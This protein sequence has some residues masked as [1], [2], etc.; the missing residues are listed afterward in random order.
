[1]EVRVAHHGPLRLADDDRAEGPRQPIGLIGDLVATVPDQ[2]QRLAGELTGD[3]EIDE[4]ASRVAIVRDQRVEQLQW[5][6][7]EIEAA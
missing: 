2:T 3:R 1:M 4:P 5:Q 7:D 6:R